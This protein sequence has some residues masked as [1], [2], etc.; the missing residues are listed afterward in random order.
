MRAFIYIRGEDIF[1]RQRVASTYETAEYVS[2]KEITHFVEISL[3]WYY[4]SE[5]AC[6]E[7]IS[8]DPGVGGLIRN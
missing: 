2:D 3:V 5:C 1:V 7:D 8:D 6:A 4:C